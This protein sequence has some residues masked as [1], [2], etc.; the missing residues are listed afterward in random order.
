MRNN[1]FAIMFIL[2]GMSSAWAV[3][4]HYVTSLKHLFFFL[5]NLSY[6]PDAMEVVVFVFFLINHPSLSL[7]SPVTL[8]S[9]RC[10][11]LEVGGRCRVK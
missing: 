10:A 3:L 8:E 9:I 6:I 1:S 7:Q 11:E 2:Y 4:V 5:A